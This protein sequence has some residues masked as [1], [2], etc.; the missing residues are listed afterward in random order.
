VET[1]IL[2]QVQRHELRPDIYPPPERATYAVDPKWAA[3]NPDLAGR[4]RGNRNY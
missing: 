1:M 4:G 2:G 3:Q